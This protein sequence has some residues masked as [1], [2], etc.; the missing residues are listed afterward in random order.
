MANTKSCTCCRN[1][2]R[3][4][5]KGR[6]SSTYSGCSWSLSLFGGRT[7]SH[8]LGS[9]TRCGLMTA[10]AACSRT[11]KSCFGITLSDKMREFGSPSYWHDFF[12]MTH[13]QKKHSKFNCSLESLIHCPIPM[14]YVP[15]PS[16]RVL[17]PSPRSDSERCSSIPWWCR[18]TDDAFSF[19]LIFHVRLK[20]IGE[21]AVF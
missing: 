20:W 3:F 11:G 8:P 21:R 6:L 12:K 7:Q 13:S 14:N 9:R 2:D 16:S 1:I 5:P 4:P 18:A 17:C 19:K 10:N 15:G